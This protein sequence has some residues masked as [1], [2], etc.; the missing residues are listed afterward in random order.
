MKI[1][2]RALHPNVFSFIRKQC[3][4]SQILPWYLERN[5][6]GMGE[7]DNCYFTH[8]YYDKDTVTSDHLKAW[9]NDVR[10]FLGVRSFMRIKANLYP[11]TD[12]LVHHK[13]HVDLDFDHNAA[14][15]YLNTNNGYTVIGDT[16]I[17]SVANR[18]L[19][20]NPQI[21]HHSTTCTDAQFRANINFNYF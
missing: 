4:E 20:F 7:E 10:D 2:D 8:L 3:C 17:E 11:R 14:I 6:S 9:G 19:L 13:D 5:I 15:L 12:T 21:P 16:K 1:I 18:I